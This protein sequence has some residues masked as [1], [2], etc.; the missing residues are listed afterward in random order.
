MLV[1]VVITTYARPVFLERAINSVFNQN[2]SE[3]EL[4][5]VDDNE[6]CS[7]AR[8]LTETI[9]NKH[10][11]IK[12]IKHA[13]NLGANA[14]RNTGI[15]KA[16]GEYIAFLD[17]DDEFFASK[18]KKQI[19]VAQKY[20]NDNGVLVFTSY[21]VIGDS[22]LQKSR[23]ANRVKNTLFF[24]ESNSIFAGNYIG[25]NSFILVDKQSLEQIN[26]YD[27]SLQSSQDW[28]L[29]IRL[30]I[31]GVKFVGINEDLVNYYSDHD[32]KRI[33]ENKEKRLSGFIGIEKKYRNEIDKLNGNIKFQYYNYL[34]RRIV[35]VDFRRG[36]GWFPKLLKN[37]SAFS[38]LLTFIISVIYPFAVILRRFILC[39]KLKSLYRCKGL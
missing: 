2:Y 22:S 11:G 18:I 23:W 15:R 12:Y 30:N 21:N 27:E 14:A 8:Y 35:S 17:D 24:P 16:K 4:I 9:I 6:P 33:T 10:K 38:H 1:S 3:I 36:W 5:I 25:S 26:Y 34:F 37:I 13:K 20:R 39:R 28:D 7:D 32:E 31:R 29:Y 19:E